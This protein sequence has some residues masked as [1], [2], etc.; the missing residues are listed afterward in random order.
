LLPILLFA[1]DGGEQRIAKAV[2]DLEKPHYSPFVERYV[3]DELKQLRI[4]Q[5]KTKNE[6][7]K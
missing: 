5:A 2:E 1:E 4:E 7:V 3:L 6:L